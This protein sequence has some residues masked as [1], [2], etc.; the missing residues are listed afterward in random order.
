VSEWLDSAVGNA[1]SVAGAKCAEIARA[2]EAVRDQGATGDSWA[3]S[4][5]RAL[6]M[7]TIKPD[8]VVPLIKSEDG[9]LE[10]NRKARRAKKAEERRV[11]KKGVK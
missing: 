7:D 2:R 9:K 6:Y 11:A 4:T 3:Y 5:Q 8:V 10:G 1:V